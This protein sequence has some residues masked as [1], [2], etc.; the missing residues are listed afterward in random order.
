MVAALRL[1]HIVA[2]AFWAGAAMLMGWIVI[3]TSRQVG[4]AAAPLIQGLIRNKLATRLI[5][6]GILTVVAGLWLYV[7]RAPAFGRWQDYALATGALA[8]IAALTIG[9]ALQRPTG[10]KL[11]Q[12]S[13]AMGGQPPNAE[14]AAELGRLQGKMASYGNTL[15]YLF[16]IALAGMALGGS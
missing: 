12:L 9:I 14:Q 2:G 5:A 10:D 1:I 3:P 16:A 6:A 8:A 7:L 4:P 15:A 13:E 11:R